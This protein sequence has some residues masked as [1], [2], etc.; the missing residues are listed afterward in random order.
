MLEPGGDHSCDDTSHAVAEKDYLLASNIMFFQNF[1][2]KPKH[3]RLPQG[4]VEAILG[5]KDSTGKVF[6]K[7]FF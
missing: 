2:G 6:G 5:C 7:R 4:E 1:F 3:L